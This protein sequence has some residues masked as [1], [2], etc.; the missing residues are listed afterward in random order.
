M[1]R[2]NLLDLYSFVSIAKEGSFT[3]AGARLGL[4]PSTLSHAMRALETR[5]GVVLLTRTTRSVALT[6]AGERL[7]LQ[8]APHLQEIEAG[9]FA[10]RE[11]REQP[12]GTIRISAIDY[13]IDTLL[14]PRLASLLEQHPDLKLE[15]A[16]DY[17]LADIVKDKF[18]IGVRS[19]D[20][21]AQDMV[22]VRIAAD[23]RLAIV[24]S[25][26]YLQRHP[27]PATPRELLQHNCISL[28]LPTFGGPYAWELKKGEQALEVKVRGQL[29]CNGVY[30]MLH[31][32]LSS[33]G[34]AYL[35]EALAQPYVAAGQLEWVL[36]AWFPTFPG[37]HIFY[38]LRRQDSR[39][40][41]LVVD[42]L[43]YRA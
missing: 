27:P 17:G 39:A 3:R 8:V 12:A 11:L 15:F 7:L 13:V 43:R 20:Q 28:Q 30:Q 14:W 22:A 6:E 19:G 10:T 42:A 34:L 41:T 38:P 36:P 32:A 33:A 25:P 1:L 37:Q 4:L 5:M 35:P 18:D 26:A 40:F 29:S 23:Y 2:E 21:V 16:I 9:L 24:A 31:A